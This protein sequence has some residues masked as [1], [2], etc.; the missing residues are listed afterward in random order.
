MK[1][2]AKNRSRRIRKKMRVDEFQ[3][4][5]FDVAWKLADGTS[6]EAIDE[7]VDKFIVEAIEPND[8]GFGGEGDV[9]WHGLICTRSLGKCTEEDRKTV[10]QWLT[11]NG[12][13]SVAVSELYDIWWS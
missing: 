4:L 3:E 6:S 10:E 5:G 12:A 11:K 2:E 7:F 1:I 8:L 9:L 13:T